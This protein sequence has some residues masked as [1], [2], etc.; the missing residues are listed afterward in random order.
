M[1]KVLLSNLYR[2]S[3]THPQLRQHLYPT[4]RQIKQ[5]A[6]FGDV[7]SL[8]NSRIDRKSL[9]ELEELI[10]ELVEQDLDQY[11]A[12]IRPYIVSKTK[13]HYERVLQDLAT[14]Y[15]KTLYHDLHLRIERSLYN[16]AEYEMER[17]LSPDHLSE[18]LNELKRDLKNEASRIQNGTL[19]QGIGRLHLE[20]ATLVGELLQRIKSGKVMYLLQA[21]TPLILKSYQE[22]VGRI[23]NAVKEDLDSVYSADDLGFL[24]DTAYQPPQFPLAGLKRVAGPLVDQLSTDAAESLA[25]RERTLLRR[26]R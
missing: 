5:A 12:Q 2:L 9:R 25:K 8:L 20:D 7:R 17:G 26:R 22:V 15:A 19:R 21:I 10:E 16:I 3:L 4:M 13:A 24:L 18:H 14:N 23:F 1:S 11:V 6:Q